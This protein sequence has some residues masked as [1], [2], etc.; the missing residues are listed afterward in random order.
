MTDILI[1]ILL[2]TVI[3]IQLLERFFYGEQVS[4]REDKLLEE[5]SRAM[6]AVIARNANEYVMTT[7]ID[8]V[9]TDDKPKPAPDEVPEEALS[10][11]QFFN[12][13]GKALKNDEN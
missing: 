10:D 8:K 11:D 3:I 1:Y 12:A 6:K 5:V 2:G 7:S 4:K 13:I 9:P